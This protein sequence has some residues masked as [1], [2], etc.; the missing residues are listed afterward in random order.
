MIAPIAPQQPSPAFPPTPGATAPAIAGDLGGQAVTG[1]DASQVLKGFR[2]QRGELANQ[3]ERL[4]DQR[5]DVTGQLANDET[6]PVDRKG[7][8]QRLTTIDQRIAQT[9]A[10][11]AI[12][13]A[14]VARAT[15]VPGA[16]VESPPPPPRTGPP[17]EFWVLG[18]IF[19]FV[20]LMPIAV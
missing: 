3:L 15:A 1:A 18:G 4:R 14:N 5:N 7:L 8:E 20:V 16:V 17:D 10:A 12:A 19:I 11:L 6:T 13:D 2:D 9:D